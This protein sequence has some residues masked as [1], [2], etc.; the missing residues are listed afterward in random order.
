M[1]HGMIGLW[2]LVNI[3]WELGISREW[4]QAVSRSSGERGSLMRKKAVVYGRFHD[5]ASFTVIDRISS[6]SG[7][8]W[9]SKRK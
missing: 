2:D 8:E 1:I 9:G 5:H 4:Y 7:P 3:Y 6:L